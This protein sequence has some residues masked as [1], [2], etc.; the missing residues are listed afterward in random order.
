MRVT[1]RVRPGASRIAVGGRYGDAE[2]PTLIVAVTARAVDGAA[3]E[4]VL[5]AVAD[6]FGVHRR[7]VALI[8]GATSRTKVLEVAL[9]ESAGQERLAE[10]LSP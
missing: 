8:N 9:D 4:A 2:P 5:R 6:A 1:V 10:L 3:T 7:H